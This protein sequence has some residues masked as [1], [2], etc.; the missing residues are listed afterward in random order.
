MWLYILLIACVLVLMLGHERCW[1]VPQHE[2]AEPKTEFE[3]LASQH[4][5][6]VEYLKALDALP[7]GPETN[8]AVDARTVDFWLKHSTVKLT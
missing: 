1:T 8:A 6:Y 4:E 2:Q 5:S 3:K 7:L